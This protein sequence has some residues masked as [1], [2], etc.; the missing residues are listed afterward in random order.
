MK[1]HFYISYAG[2]K[3]EEVEEIY[4]NLNFDG[5]NTIIE[6]FCGSCAMS[7][8]ISLQRRN[9]KY[10]LNDND[11][12]LKLMYEVLINDD[13]IKEFEESFKKNMLY[14]GRSKEKYL[15]VIKKN[16]LMGWFI[17]NKVYCLRVGL[18]PNSE[19]EIDNIIKRKGI[20]NLKSFPIYDFFKN[21]DI[22]FYNLDWLEI[23]DKYKNN[24]NCLI[25]FD[26]PYI[27]TC[28]DFYINGSLNI[29]EYM[30]YNH[31]ENEKARIYFILENIW[32]IQLLFNSYNKV[33]Y[34]KKYNGIKKK[35]VNHIII[36][37]Q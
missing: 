32:I 16:D 37:N 31:M 1:N 17:K 29:Y 11:L 18:F 2:N 3:R 20:I 15:E 10:I 8:Y 30:F 28:N 24:D 12:Y 36:C 13:K 23:Y 5:I 34:E 14:I 4:K 26:P 27:S 6:P 33:I 22:E 9:L 7:Y 35:T 19:K 25:L 21:N